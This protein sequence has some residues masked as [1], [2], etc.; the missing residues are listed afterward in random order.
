MTASFW[1]KHDDGS[2]V[3]GLSILGSASHSSPGSNIIN[4]FVNHRLKPG[5]I[6]R[7]KE[8][9]CRFGWTFKVKVN[10]NK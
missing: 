2:S 4:N 7:F 1:A 6:E 8:I 5:L 9:E 3:H 10:I